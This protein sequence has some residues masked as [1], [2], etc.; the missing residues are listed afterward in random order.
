MHPKNMEAHLDWPLKCVWLGVSVED[1]AR[2][3]ERIPILLDTPAAVRWVS[4]EPLLSPVD[5]KRLHGRRVMPGG[6]DEQWWESCL[7][8][9][10]F[11]IWSE[12]DIPAPKLDWVVVG[13]ESGPGS[14]PMR[15]DWARQIRDDCAAAGVAFFLKQ[16]SGDNGHAI[17]EIERFPA[18]LQVRQYPQ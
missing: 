3:H 16:L 18:D 17:K 9:K 13:G 1:Q 5:L 12:R 6:G 7:N 11:D 14:R 15:P 8:G 4:L 10:R 2:A